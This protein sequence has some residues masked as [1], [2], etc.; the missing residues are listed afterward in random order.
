MRFLGWLVAGIGFF[1]VTLFV[2]GSALHAPFIA[3]D[4][5]GLIYTNPIVHSISWKTITDAF[6]T[7]DPELYI[8][9]TFLSYQIDYAIGGLQPF[10]YHVDNL[11]LHTIN[12]LLVAGLTYTL[13]R[14]KI[15]ALF[16]GLLFAV[17]PLHTEAVLWIASRKDLLSTAFFLLSF[18]LYL[19]AQREH[20]KYL[21]WFS[22]SIACLLLAL[23]SK[24]MAMTLP[25]VLL[26]ADILLLHRSLSRRVLLE[27]IPYVFLAIV[28][29]VI[30]LVGKEE[31]IASTTPFQILLMA[32]KSTMF[33]ATKLFWPSDLSFFYPYIKPI[34]L[35]S[36]DFAIPLIGV[37]V[38]LVL[39]LW[40]WK[41]LP[42]ISFGILFFL[43]TVSPT[44]INIVKNEETFFA[45][46]RYAYL[47]S[48]GIFFLLAALAAGATDANRKKL[49]LLAGTV[50]VFTLL[51]V[52]R[53]ETLLWKDSKT[54]FTRSVALYPDTLAGTYNLGI[55][56]R[57]SGEL[58]KALQHFE[59][60]LR[61]RP[62]SEI[63]NNIAATLRLQGKAT[64][65]L[66][67]YN[68]ALAMD[69][70][71]SEAYAGIGETNAELGNDDAAEAAYKKALEL[72][73]GYVA[74]FNN[75]G[76]FYLSKG[77]V[78]EAENMLREAVRLQP[79]FIDG[80]YNLAA[81]LFVQKKFSDAKKEYG[82]I[83]SMKPDEV[84]A[85]VGLARIAFTEGERKEAVRLLG[86]ALGIDKEDPGAV[87]LLLEIRKQ[88]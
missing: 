42:A 48:F 66:L 51:F 83:L 38:L 41:R 35:S 27:K 73:P 25:V 45:V 76:T 63:E 8:P 88:L 37:A 7:Y 49:W 1:I 14:K 61:L 36:P 46:N 10:V 32:G 68:K 15:P 34:T 54:L 31:V 82:E 50:S 86:L 18:L 22:L 57:E 53:A 2:F 80:H 19:T 43:V 20:R 30:G 84:S 40:L 23:L 64:E 59:A 16:A 69:P 26:L 4:E 21:L 17:H 62:L 52:A 60:A 39:V 6:T 9:L 67:H 56:E 13:L 81:L 12:A 85:L 70:R 65:A 87:K 78:A 74:V 77:R 47:P 5:I 33:Y 71:N 11:L 44:F 58:A 29:V 79:D 55:V 24:V 3:S 75:L 72:N 28:F